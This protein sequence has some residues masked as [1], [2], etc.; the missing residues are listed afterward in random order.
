MVHGACMVHAWWCMVHAW[1]MHGGA[2]CMHGGAW[3]AHSNHEKG[4]KPCC[5]LGGCCSGC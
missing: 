5:N 2:L 1:C 4:D 3:V